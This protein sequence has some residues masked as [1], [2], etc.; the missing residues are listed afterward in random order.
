MNRWL[1]VLPWVSVAISIACG[2]GTM[3]L[4][5]RSLAD[6]GRPGAPLIGYL[7]PASWLGFQVVG[8]MLL[9]AGVRNRIAVILLAIGSS[10]FVNVG[11]IAYA[12]QTLVIDPNSL[13]FGDIAGWLSSWT[14][15]PGLGSIPLL[16]LLFPT[17]RP[18]NERWRR[19]VHLVVATTVALT[20]WLMIAP[21]EIAGG[22]QNMPR[23]VNP[24]GIEQLGGRTTETVTFT[25]SAALFILGL[26]GAVSMVLRMRRGD[27]VERQQLK[28]LAYSVMLLPLI[29]FG[30]MWLQNS[31]GEQS[32]EVVIIVGFVLAFNTVAIAMGMSIVRYR[33]YD[34]DLVINRTLVYLLL[35]AVL[36]TSY[37]LIVFALGRLLDPVTR[38]SDIAVAASTLVVAALFRPLRSRVQSFIDQRFYRSRYDAT[39]ELSRLVGRL[40]DEVDLKIVRAEVVGVVN[41]TVQPASA[42]LWLREERSS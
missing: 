2:V 35:T 23:F 20:L 39:R 41:S 31:L 11:S 16:L 4:E 42:S 5:Q 1:R 38:D 24:F 17:G 14:V 9:S 15:V 29:I 3:W 13:P 30:A 27:G 34:F 12:R 25:L 37:L 28:I 33:L 26:A 32:G 18:L 21:V 19:A 8:A 22:P 10:V 36:L 7:W 6:L 40:R